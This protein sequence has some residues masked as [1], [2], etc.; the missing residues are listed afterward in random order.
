MVEQNN[1]V[2]RELK[3]FNM[4]EPDPTSLNVRELRGMSVIEELHT[5]PPLNIHPQ[6]PICVHSA[7]Q[8]LKKKTMIIVLQHI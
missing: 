2:A 8:N 6:C 3:W 5:Y 1:K 7:V 4:K